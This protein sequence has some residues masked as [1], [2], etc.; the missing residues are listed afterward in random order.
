[1]NLFISKGGPHKPR[2]IGHRQNGA[3]YDDDQWRPAPHGTP[4]AG[5]PGNRSDGVCMATPH[6]PVDGSLHDGF[7]ADK[8]K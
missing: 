3:Q 5:F 7:F 8:P 6:A 2:R 4:E 1:M